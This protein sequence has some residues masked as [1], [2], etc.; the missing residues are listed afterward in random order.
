[1]CLSREPVLSIK[2]TFCLNENCLFKQGKEEV[3]E[4]L[5]AQ[6]TEQSFLTVDYQ[7]SY[8]SLMITINNYY[9][10]L[11]NYLIKRQKPN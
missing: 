11:V 7:L 3:L 10:I 4:V 1:M 8:Y 6:N 5:K 9:Y 2:T